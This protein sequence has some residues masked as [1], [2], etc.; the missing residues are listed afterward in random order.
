MAHPLKS[1]WP[2]KICVALG[3]CILTWWSAKAV[4]HGQRGSHQASM[5]SSACTPH[6]CPVASLGQYIHTLL[7]W[8]E[9]KLDRFSRDTRPRIPCI[10]VS[11]D[12][13][14]STARAPL[15]E[16][17]LASSEHCN[18]LD[19]FLEAVVDLSITYVNGVLASTA[20]TCMAQMVTHASLRGAQEPVDAKQK[21]GYRLNVPHARV[22]DNYISYR[23]AQQ[24]SVRTW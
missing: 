19:W 9:L 4:L 20:K 16:T 12:P 14:E 15:T 17:C 5:S 7:P 11:Q 2:R 18:F 8:S 13:M 22:R 21:R 23:R 1:S 24:F 10:S 3:Y 6:I